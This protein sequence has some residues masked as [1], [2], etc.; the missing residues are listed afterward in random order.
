MVF[1]ELQEELPVGAVTL[2]EEAGQGNSRVALEAPADWGWPR[3]THR[4][5]MAR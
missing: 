3:A 5:F 4:Y 1:V 2:A